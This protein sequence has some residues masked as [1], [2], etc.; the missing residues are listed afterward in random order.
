[1]KVLIVDDHPVLRRGLKEILAEEYKTLAVGEA[2]NGQEALRLVREQ[3]WDIVVLDI[4]MPGHN[5]I[6]TLKEIRRLRPK[7]P[8]LILT[9]YPEEQYAVRVLK[10]G[11]RGYLT[12]ESAPEHLTAAIRKVIKDGYYVSPSL[13]DVLALSLTGEQERPLYEQLSDREFQVLCMI[14]SGKTVSQIAAELFLSV[15]TISTYRARVLEK[16][17]MKTNAELTHYAIRNKL[18]G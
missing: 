12:K 17:R 18:I 3:E 11:A 16:M 15:K 10:A 2:Q 14:A 4:S 6:E 1:V 5:G 13:A 9:S 8:V 7:L